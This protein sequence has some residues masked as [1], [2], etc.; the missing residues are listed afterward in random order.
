M[1][2]RQ[3]SWPQTR[4]VWRQFTLM[5]RVMERLDVDPILAARKSGGAAMANARDICRGCVLHREC[6]RLVEQDSDRAR[7]AELCPNAEFFHAC[8]RTECSSDL[9]Q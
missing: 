6:R 5:D 3:Q 4:Q 9:S 8:G 7:L 1:R 2:S